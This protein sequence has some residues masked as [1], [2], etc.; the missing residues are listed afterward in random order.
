VGIYSFAICFHQTENLFIVLNKIVRM[1]G[2]IDTCMFFRT[3]IS[4]KP[5]FHYNNCDIL[6]FYVH[7]VSFI[8]QIVFAKFHNT[9][10]NCIIFA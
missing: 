7:N 6:R 8:M 10:Y 9:F 5:Q 2:M 4:G 1:Y 3:L